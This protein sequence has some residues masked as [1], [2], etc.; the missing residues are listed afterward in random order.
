MIFLLFGYFIFA[1]GSLKPTVELNEL[2]FDKDSC[3]TVELYVYDLDQDYVPID[4]VRL[5]TNRDTLYLPDSL[6]LNSDGYKVISQK[7]METDFNINWNGDSLVLKYHPFV[8]E[9]EAYWELV[10]GNKSNAVIGSPLIGQSIAKCIYYVKD[11]SPT[12]GTN[13]DTTGILGTLKG[14]I[15]DK[16]GVPVANKEFWLEMFKFTTAQDG[17]YLTRMFSRPTE[18]NDMYYQLSETLITSVVFDEINFTM[19]PDSVITRD[20]HLIGNIVTDLYELNVVGEEVI[21][22]PNPIKKSDKLNYKLGFSLKNK[23]ARFEILGIDSGTKSINYTNKKEG[24]LDISRFNGLIIINLV[25]EDEV[26]SSDKI[27]IAN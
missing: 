15:F 5:I 12:I 17:S 11:D 1:Q 9:N 7:D 8:C 27:M 2:Y 20:I 18:L 22:Y 24:E 13:N 3:W 16:N 25:I 4:N 19:E 14:M 10:F 26:I 21:Y 23:N 6:V